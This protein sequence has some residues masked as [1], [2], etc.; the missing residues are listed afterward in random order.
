[1]VNGS[2]VSC[3]EK[4]RSPMQMEWCTG[5]FGCAYKFGMYSENVAYFYQ[6][7]PKRAAVL[8]V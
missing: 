8:C 7:L 6:V 4:L 2:L 1:M 5:V 3:A